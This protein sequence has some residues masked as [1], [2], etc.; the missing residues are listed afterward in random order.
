VCLY[1]GH[2]GEPTETAEVIIMH[3][4]SGVLCRKE[5]GTMY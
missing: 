2:I 1:D 4:R 5:L 3:L